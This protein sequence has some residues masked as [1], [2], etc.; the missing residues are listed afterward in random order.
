MT[1]S[2]IYFLGSERKAQFFSPLETKDKENL[3]PNVPPFFSFN[4]DKNDKDKAN[5]DKI[6]KFILKEG[7]TCG[8]FT[9][10]KPTTEFIKSWDSFLKDKEFVKFF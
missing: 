1:K 8:V 9:K 4:R 2:G 6:I 3:H 10:D 5:F 7:N